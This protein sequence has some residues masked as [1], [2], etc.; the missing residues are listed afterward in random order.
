MKNLRR[1]QNSPKA[2]FVLPIPI[3]SID[4]LILRGGDVSAS[5]TQFSAY[6]I[7]QSGGGRKRSERE[8]VRNRRSPNTQKTHT[9][10]KKIGDRK[11]QIA[12]TVKFPILL[13]YSPPHC[14][15]FLLRDS[16]LTSEGE[17]QQR[18]LQTSTN[19]LQIIPYYS[20]VLHNVLFVY[21]TLANYRL[22]L[23]FC[24]P[25]RFLLFSFRKF[26]R[27]KIHWRKET[28]RGG[29]K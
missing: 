11:F 7:Q 17:I 21:K 6:V 23:S 2:A 4:R 3:P 18:S 14:V 5:L 20:S 26:L 29:R 24:P 8:N 22:C 12:P 25:L 9:R 27:R 28:E 16:V 13:S 10:E 15:S 19:A 1:Y